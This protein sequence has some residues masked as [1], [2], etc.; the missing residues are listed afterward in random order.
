M[1]T[2]AY[3]VTTILDAGISVVKRCKVHPSP[4]GADLTGGEEEDK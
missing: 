4:F 3:V 2:L 1:I